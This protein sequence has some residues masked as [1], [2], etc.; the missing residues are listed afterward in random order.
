MVTFLRLAAPTSFCTNG[1]F[2]VTN[3]S[4]N[5]GFN[6]QTFTA[7][8]EVCYNGLYGAVCLQGW[9]EREAQVICEHTGHSSD[10]NYSKLGLN[11]HS[12]DTTSL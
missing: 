5:T 7:M 10:F 2:R 6:F 8:V 1:D 11:T 9:D 3:Q 12:L 4:Y